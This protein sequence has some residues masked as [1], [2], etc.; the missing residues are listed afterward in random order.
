MENVQISIES[1]IK[2]NN[3]FF[4]SEKQAEFLISELKAQYGNQFVSSIY[5]NSVIISYEWD[6]KGIISKSN[7]SVKKNSVKVVWKRKVEGE[8]SIAEQE[9]V[10]QLKRNIKKIQKNI[11]N[12]NES[13]ERGDYSEMEELYNNSNNSD[14]KQL[15]DYEKELSKLV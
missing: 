12:R 1:L 5:N 14:L 15:S 8:L 7:Q 4:K 3:G 13:F 10:K 2:S 11:S 6:D 9:S